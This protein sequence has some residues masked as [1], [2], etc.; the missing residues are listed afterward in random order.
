MSDWACAEC[1]EGNPEL[2]DDGK[3]IVAEGLVC[4]V[5]GRPAKSLTIPKVDPYEDDL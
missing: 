5:C 2:Y 1:A 4:E 3:I